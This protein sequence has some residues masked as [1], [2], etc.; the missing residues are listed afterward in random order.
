MT[1]NTNNRSDQV[2]AQLYDEPHEEL[3]Y[4]VLLYK[5]KDIIAIQKKLG[6][7]PDPRKG[8]IESRNQTALNQSKKGKILEDS[9]GLLFDLVGELIEIRGD[10][11]VDCHPV[12]T[13]L[14]NN[15]HDLEGETY[16]KRS[17]G[18]LYHLL[19]Y[20]KED[21]SMIQDHLGIVS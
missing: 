6:M 2:D 17:L 13:I 10:L 19:L 11:D 1:G 9:F 20:L 14:Y 7:F 18:T 5:K 15:M 16:G 21:I 8:P 4:E 3:L 12:L